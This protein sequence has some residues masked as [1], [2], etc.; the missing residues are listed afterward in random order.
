MTLGYPTRQ[1]TELLSPSLNLVLAKGAGV[2]QRT[3]NGYIEQ[4]PER[5]RSRHSVSP[6]W[7]QGRLHVLLL[8]HLLILLLISLLIASSGGFHNHASS[9]RLLTD[10]WMALAGRST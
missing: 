6:D 7:G 3:S 1:L 5:T 9:Q 4:T 8:S 10:P 2:T